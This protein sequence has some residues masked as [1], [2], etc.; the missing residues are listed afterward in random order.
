MYYQISHKNI[1]YLPAPVMP[2]S[3]KFDFVIYHRKYETKGNEFI[4]RIITFL[5]NNNYKIAVI[6]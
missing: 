3:K 1:I 6:G 2:P 4:E 5:T